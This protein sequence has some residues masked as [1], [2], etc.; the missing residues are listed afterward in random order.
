MVTT[1]EVYPPPGSGD[2][3]LEVGLEVDSRDR[4]AMSGLRIQIAF[5][6]F[7]ALIIASLTA[8][9]F[10]LVS[11]IFAS[12]TP[13]IRADLEHKALRGSAEIAHA[14]DLSIAVRDPEQ[15]L[16]SLRGY[17]R[18]ADVLS[19]VATDAD[20]QVLFQHGSPPDAPPSLL[21]GGPDV[22]HAGRDYVSAWS[23]SIIEGPLVGTVVVA[24]STA[25][26]RA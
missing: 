17:E 19:I 24:V 13:S 23:P 6:A 25:R 22:L 8:L 9:V 4:K 3:P 10:G 15:I 26:L 16:N 12:L 18:E 20:G 7:I 1:A 11:H 14:A 21:S 2:M 5:T